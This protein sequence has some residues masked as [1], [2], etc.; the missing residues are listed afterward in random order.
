MKVVV[1][2]KGEFVWSGMLRSWVTFES[3]EGSETNGVSFVSVGRRVSRGCPRFP[4]CPEEG[5]DDASGSVFLVGGV[6]E[7]AP[8]GEAGL[9]KHISLQVAT[10]RGRSQ[11]R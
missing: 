7:C 6:E 8:F 4:P 9:R 11:V 3:F 10:S 1:R 2:R 5:G